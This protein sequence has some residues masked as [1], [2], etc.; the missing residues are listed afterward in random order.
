[1][2]FTGPFTWAAPLATGHPLGLPRDP[3]KPAPQHRVPATSQAHS[4]GDFP[5]GHPPAA[6]WR[7]LDGRP[8]PATHVAPPSIMQLKITQ[9]L[10]A[11]ASELADAMPEPEPKGTPQQSDAPRTE[12]GPKPDAPALPSPGHEASEDSLSRNSVFNTLP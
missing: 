10:D 4:S 7:V 5:Q 8:D 2:H 3:R 11:Q 9:M 12:A 6:Y 1:M